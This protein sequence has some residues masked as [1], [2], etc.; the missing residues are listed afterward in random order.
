LVIEVRAIFLAAFA[1]FCGHS[2][3]PFRNLH[4]A[5]SISPMLYPLRRLAFLRMGLFV[6]C[7]S[8]SL[9]GFAQAQTSAPVNR[10]FEAVVNTYEA[11]DKATPPPQGA[12]LLAGDSQFYRWKTFHEDLAGYT[13]INRGVDSFQTSDVLHYADRII[14]PYKPRL[15]ILH[16]GGND[17][18]TGKDAARILAD[19]KALV[20]KI[21]TA[22][23]DVPIAFTSTTPSPARWAEADMRKATN[24]A[25]KEYIATQKNLLFIDLW[26]AFLGPDGKPRTDLFV[27]DQIHPNHDGYL[28]RVKIMGPI[29]GPPDR[30][31]AVPPANAAAPVAAKPEAAK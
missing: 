20:A 9:G 11:A 21:R 27:E 29:L 7:L 13:V 12:I 10:Q 18:H 24:K 8:A 3:A 15:I 14:L 17:V 26:D 28:I 2:S 6:S 19:F 25:L 30:K 16:V 31:P 4:P 5:F 22:L 1:F 23:P